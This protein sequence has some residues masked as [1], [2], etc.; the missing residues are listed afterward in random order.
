M[1]CL[2]YKSLSHI[3]THKSLPFFQEDGWGG[4]E[5]RKKN[6][7]EIGSEEAEKKLFNYRETIR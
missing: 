5:N 7:M 2:I 1:F 6:R 4:E 3:E